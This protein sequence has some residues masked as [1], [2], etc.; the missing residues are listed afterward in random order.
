VYVEQ[1]DGRER[2][3]P[4]SPRATNNKTIAVEPTLLRLCCGN[5]ITPHL[6]ETRRLPLDHIEFVAVWR[7]PTCQ[8]LTR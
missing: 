5:L 3:L 6:A 1:K 4:E 2:T 8:R 7:C